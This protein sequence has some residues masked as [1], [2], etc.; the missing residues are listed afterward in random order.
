MTD[1]FG[2]KLFE[3]LMLLVSPPS[4]PLFPPPFP[5]SFLLSLFPSSFPSLPPS[6]PTLPP[7][8]PPRVQPGQCFHL[9]TKLQLSK[10][11]DFQLPEML[12]TPLEE[13]VLQ[14]K[15]L[16]LG[17]VIP[18]LAK[19]IEPPSNKA[20]RNALECLKELVRC[21]QIHPMMSVYCFP[22]IH[23]EC[24]H[25]LWG[26]NPSWLPPGQPSC[27]PPYWQDHPLC[28][29]VLLPWPCPHHR[30]SPWVQRTFCHPSGKRLSPSLIMLV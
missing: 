25:N 5:L 21:L 4:C 26:T 9:F 15:I 3:I 27:Q 28:S 8:H 10:L 7:S 30:C 14:I 1:C 16:R 12:R 24:P 17:E 11:A 23:L 6:S 18:F 29:H 13:L 2:I 22:P 19:A 20:V